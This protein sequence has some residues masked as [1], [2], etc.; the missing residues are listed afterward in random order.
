MTITL[1][2]GHCLDVLPTLPSG[3]AQAVITSPPYWQQRNYGGLDAQWGDWIGELGREPTVRQF[4]D[5]LVSVFAQVRRVLKDDGVLWVNIGDTYSTGKD[6]TF[7]A[8]CLIGVPWRFALAMIDD[9]WILRQDIIWHKSN[10]LPESVTDRCTKA[11]EYIFMFVRQADYLWNHD[12]MQEQAVQPSGQVI[13]SHKKW[14]P[15][16]GAEALLGGKHTHSGFSED[17]IANGHRNKRSVWT[18]GHAA[19]NM[20]HFASF[21]AK[22]VVPMVMASS[23]VGDTILDVFSGTGTTACVASSLGRVG[24]GIDI[25]ETYHEDA[26]KRVLRTNI[27]FM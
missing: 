22:L 19:S 10:A 5:N 27:G 11:H 25:N 13:A 23:A 7:A 8:K 15:Q 9:G 24:I 1:L 21:P 2:H 20:N 14:H 12:A 18:L 3:S 17:W 4:V 16:N 26:M 6:A